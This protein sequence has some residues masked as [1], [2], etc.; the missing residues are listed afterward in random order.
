MH[1]VL[2][3]RPHTVA[4]EAD[5]TGPH[6]SLCLNH[7]MRLPT[8]VSCLLS[9]P[10]QELGQRDMGAPGRNGIAGLASQSCLPVDHRKL[11]TI[12]L[13]LSIFRQGLWGQACT[14]F[15]QSASNCFMSS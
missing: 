12:P 15:L 2:S 4:V 7:Q 3:K 14:R 5:D 13:A 10:K 6:T 9:V 1:Y 11:C 8:H